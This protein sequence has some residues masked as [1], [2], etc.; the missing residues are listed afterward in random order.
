MRLQITSDDLEPTRTHISIDGVALGFVQR[1]DLQV[2]GN[3]ARAVF[4]MF[5]GAENPTR[6]DVSSGQSLAMRRRSLERISVSTPT[7]HLHIGGSTPNTTAVQ[8]RLAPVQRV[9][10]YRLTPRESWG[11][12]EQEAA[13]A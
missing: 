12:V 13:S 1:F 9:G 6:I 4:H 7:A 11:R 8:Q 3:E 2:G 10:R 5:G